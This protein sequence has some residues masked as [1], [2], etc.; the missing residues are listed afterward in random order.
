MLI[1]LRRLLFFKLQR[2]I[3]SE[4]ENYYDEFLRIERRSRAEVEAM[5]FESLQRLLTFAVKH[6]PYYREHVHSENDPQPSDFPVLTKQ[7]LREHFK[8]LMTADLKEEYLS[9]HR[10]RKFYSWA[11]VKTGGSTGIPTS[12]IHDKQFRDQGRASRLYSQYLCGFPFGTSHIKLWGSMKDINQS[13]ESVP[14]RVM[15]FLSGETLLNAFRMG[16]H[17]MERFI[18]Y[19]NR[20]KPNY[21]MAYVDAADHLAT[22]AREKGKSI[23]PLQTIMS[24]AGTVTENIRSNL[25]NV[26]HA[27]VHNKYGSRDCGD[28]ACECE[29]GGMHIYTNNVY[30]EVVDSANRPVPV[31]TAGRI[32]I[33]LLG[34]YSF[35][36]IRYEIGDVGVLSNERC[37]CGRP[38]PLLKELQGR[39]VEFLL[40]PDGGYVSPV[41]IRHLIGVV[42]NS[43]FIKRFQLVQESLT[44]CELRL[45][46]E[47][48]ISKDEL[49]ICLSKI[50]HDLQTVFGDKC[51]ISIKRT[52]FIPETENG[53][54]LY[55]INK[56]GAY[57]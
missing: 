14:H 19:L 56:V 6:V 17:D 39:T 21:L 26:F 52:T 33:T 35:P 54:F 57:T 32:L 23:K 36:L 41:Y 2:A 15:S 53:K 9:S 43:G 37:P 25:Q 11:E 50:L 28:I 40:T 47:P 49:K 24:C 22:Y 34:N 8:E 55:T 45:E 7:Q 4:V 1:D 38:F 44:S 42:H 30:L 18:D 27:R 3:G 10:R 12:V 46:M 31:G 13:K 29:C 48:N 51:T 20:S 5:Q 16:E